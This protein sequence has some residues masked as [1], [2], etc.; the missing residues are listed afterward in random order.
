MLGQHAPTLEWLAARV[1]EVTGADWFRLD[2]FMREERAERGGGEEGAAGGGGPRIAPLVVNEL[3]YPGHLLIDVSAAV[4]PAPNGSNGSAAAAPRD[5][6]D[7]W[8]RGYRHGTRQLGHGSS[9]ADA[10]LA[11]LGIAP[12]AFAQSD[13]L[14]MDRP[15]DAHFFDTTRGT[16]DGSLASRCRP[17][18]CSALHTGMLAHGVT[19][20]LTGAGG[21]TQN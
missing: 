9:H 19:R 1:H 2:T 3:T 15:R 14:S 16:Y 10:L 4:P 18:E 8:L 6:L 13:F 21:P 17:A 12:R 11:R 20:R 7:S 5:S